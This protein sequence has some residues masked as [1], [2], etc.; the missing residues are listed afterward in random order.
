MLNQS[1]RADFRHFQV[2]FEDLFLHVILDVSHV[3][4]IRD[5]LVMRYIYVRFTYLLTYLTEP[6]DISCLRH[7]CKLGVQDAQDTSCTTHWI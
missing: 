6:W 5:F 7:K 3:Q 4:C 1:T 2:S